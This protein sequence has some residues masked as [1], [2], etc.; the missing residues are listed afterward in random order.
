[1]LFSNA[2]LTCFLMVQMNVVELLLALP[3]HLM[4]CFATQQPLPAAAGTDTAY[5]K[6]YAL[7][8]PEC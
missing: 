4:A 8:V 2:V 5:Y 6:S 3:V 7:S 1:M